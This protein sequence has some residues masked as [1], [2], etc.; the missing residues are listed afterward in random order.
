MAAG[1]KRSGETTKG[2]KAAVVEPA[3]YVTGESD[4]TRTLWAHTPA[5]LYITAQSQ[6]KPKL[7]EQAASTAN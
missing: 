2:K 1:P 3:G 6:K 4:Y 5:M 7:S